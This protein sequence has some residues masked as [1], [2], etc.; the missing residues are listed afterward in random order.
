MLLQTDG[1]NLTPYT[2]PGR[3]SEVEGRMPEEGEDSMTGWLTVRGR[4]E[5]QVETETEEMETPQARRNLDPV[6]SP[7]PRVKVG[8]ERWWELSMVE[9]NMMELKVAEWEMKRKEASQKS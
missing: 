8:S 6:P 7:P 4:K 9:L 2:R 3:T 5:C 1:A